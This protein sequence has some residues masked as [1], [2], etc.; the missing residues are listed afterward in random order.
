MDALTIL[1]I[2][3]GIFTT[4]SIIPQ[5]KKAWET[6]KVDD[7]SSLWLIILIIGVVLW[8][9]YGVIKKDIPIIATNGV[10][11]LLNAGLLIL[12]FKYRGEN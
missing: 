1:G 6:K 12:Y 11:A 5:I 4:A 9:I 8:T 3:A 7:L 2:A 10:A